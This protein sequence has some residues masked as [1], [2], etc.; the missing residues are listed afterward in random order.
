LDDHLGRVG[1]ICQTLGRARLSLPEGAIS[2]H[3]RWP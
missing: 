3:N 1:V 2:R